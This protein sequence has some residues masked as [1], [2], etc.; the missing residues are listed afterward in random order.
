M[1]AKDEQKLDAM[2]DA[3]EHWVREIFNSMRL[4]D[5]AYNYKN[6]ARAE[7]KSLIMQLSEEGDDDGK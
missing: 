5:D 7:L 6:E 3:I 1:N 2:L 4:D